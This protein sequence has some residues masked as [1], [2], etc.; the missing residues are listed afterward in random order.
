MTKRIVTAG[1]ELV[2]ARPAQAQRNP[3]EGAYESMPSFFQ[4]PE[5]L[6]FRGFYA[7][8][9]SHTVRV[10]RAT[11]W[12]SSLGFTSSRAP[13]RTSRTS[14]E[15]LNWRTQKLGIAPKIRSPSVALFPSAQRE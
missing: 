2:L 10:D 12:L 15:L 7:C 1:A 5:H 13:P 9:Y 11:P 8:V 14:Q 6:H 3:P 4:L